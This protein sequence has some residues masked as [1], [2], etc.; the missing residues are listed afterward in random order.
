MDFPGLG[1]YLHATFTVG[2]VGGMSETGNKANSASKEIELE[3]NWGEAELGN[4]NVGFD[5][6]E[7]P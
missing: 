1:L 7:I 2:W 5:N 3:L 6:T 4:N